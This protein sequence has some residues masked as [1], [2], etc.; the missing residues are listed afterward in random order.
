M[1]LSKNMI[2]VGAHKCDIAHYF[3]LPHIRLPSNVVTALLLTTS[4][5]LAMASSWFYSMLD[6]FLHGKVAMLPK[7]D[8]YHEGWIEFLVFFAI[9]IYGLYCLLKKKE[10]AFDPPI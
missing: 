10:I 6:A 4:V 2:E 5:T 1:E 3:R 7:I 9:G 8:V